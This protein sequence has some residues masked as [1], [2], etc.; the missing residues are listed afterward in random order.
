MGVFF[1]AGGPCERISAA[2]IRA[3]AHPCWRPAVDRRAESADP[4]PGPFH[5]GVIVCIEAKSKPGVAAPRPA[6]TAV[7]KGG[8]RGTPAML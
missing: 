5:S 8:L 7:C 6:L 4:F 2:I 3:W 1:V